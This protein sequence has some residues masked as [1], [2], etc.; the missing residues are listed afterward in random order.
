MGYA[1]TLPPRIPR[2]DGAYEFRQSLLEAHTSASLAAASRVITPSEV[3]RV[4]VLQGYGVP[5]DRVHAIHHGVDHDLFRPDVPGGRELVGAP[6][7]LFVGVLHP[8]KNLEAVRAAV[9]GLAWPAW[10]S[11]TSWPR[12]GT[13]LLIELS[14][15]T[16][17]RSSSSHR[18]LDGSGCFG[19]SVIATSSRS[20]QA[21]PP[22]ACR[23]SSR[24]SGSRRSRRWPVARR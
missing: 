14:P 13:P 1:P 18:S 3:S 23:A 6:Y 8:R 17:R 16:R 20:C 7:V 22:S 9:P 12:S 24:A 19:S 11:R 4:Q 21:L 5:S 10:D 15:L 2:R